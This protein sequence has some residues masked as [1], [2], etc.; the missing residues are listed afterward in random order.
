MLH[1]RVDR[2]HCE[3]EKQSGEKVLESLIVM[4]ESYD[5]N[6]THARL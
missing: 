2:C 5:L 4:F 6:G 1:V 3:G